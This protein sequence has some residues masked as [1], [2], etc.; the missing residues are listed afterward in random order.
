MPLIDEVISLHVAV[1]GHDAGEELAKMPGIRTLRLMTAP[2][3]ALAL[4]VHQAA[5]Y[6]GL[7]PQTVDHSM[8]PRETI[9][10][11]TLR[12]QAPLCHPQAIVIHASLAFFDSVNTGHNA[13]L[14]RVGN[15]DHCLLPSL[16][17]GAIHDQISERRQVVDWLGSLIQVTVNNPSHSAWR[18]AAHLAELA[19]TV[20][21]NHPPLKPN[22]L[23]S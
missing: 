15:T 9:D 17:V 23:T 3:I 13:V 19:H 18:I 10:S 12:R 2:R 20:P 14:S 5:L 8:N 16:E 11:D 22:A 4:N 7:W 6:D 21:L 1:N